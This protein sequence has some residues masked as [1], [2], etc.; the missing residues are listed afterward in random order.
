MSVIRSCGGA[1][2]MGEHPDRLVSPVVLAVVQKEERV[3]VEA[4]VRAEVEVGVE[5]AVVA[6]EDRSHSYRSHHNLGLA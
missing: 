4:V 6:G 2:E 3:A 1:R 5:P